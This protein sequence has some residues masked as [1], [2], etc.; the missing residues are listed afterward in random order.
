MTNQ[1]P[2]SKHRRGCSHDW[3]RLYQ[4]HGR[5]STDAASREATRPQSP[6]RIAWRED[7]RYSRATALNEGS[8]LA[9]KVVTAKMLVSIR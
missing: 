6:P 9:P 3:L 7:G 4:F 5:A 8:A 2:R 1:Q